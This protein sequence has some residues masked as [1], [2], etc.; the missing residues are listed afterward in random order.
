VDPWIYVQGHGNPHDDT[1]ATSCPHRQEITREGLIEQFE[2]VAGKP[3]EGLFKENIDEMV[4]K[5][6]TFRM[7]T[8]RCCTTCVDVPDVCKQLPT[9]DKLDGW[10]SCWLTHYPEKWW[11]PPKEEKEKEE[12]EEEAPCKNCKHY[13]PDTRYCSK[14][15]GHNHGCRWYHVGTVDGP[16]SGDHEHVNDLFESKEEKEVK[17]VPPQHYDDEGW[18]IKAP[19]CKDC[20]HRHD[21]TVHESIFSPGEHELSRCGADAGYW[22]ARTKANSGPGVQTGECR[23]HEGEKEE[24]E[25]EVKEEEEKE[26][27]CELC[28]HYEVDQHPRCGVGGGVR[29]LNPRDGCKWFHPTIMEWCT[30]NHIHDED[31]FEPK[32]IEER[33][34]EEEKKC[35]SCGTCGNGIYKH[36]DKP[37]C[38]TSKLT[39]CIYFHD[40]RTGPCQSPSIPH[41]ED[42]W[43]PKKIEVLEV[44]DDDTVTVELNSDE[45]EYIGKKKV[46]V[47]C[48][49]CEHAFDVFKRGKAWWCSCRVATPTMSNEQFYTNNKQC[50]RFS[51]YD[52]TADRP[53]DYACKECA[54]NNLKKPFDTAP[55]NGPPFCMKYF[56]FDDKRGCGGRNFRPRSILKDP[57]PLVA[58]RDCECASGVYKDDDGWK[59]RCKHVPTGIF[60]YTDTKICERFSRYEPPTHH[61]VC[62]DGCAWRVTDHRECDYHDIFNEY[63]L[64]GVE[65]ISHKYRPAS[66]LK[67]NEDVSNVIKHRGLGTLDID[68]DDKTPVY[69][70]A[71]TKSPGGRVDVDHVSVTGID[72]DDEDL[73]DTDE[74]DWQYVAD[75]GD[76]VHQH[77]TEIVDATPGVYVHCHEGN[78]IKTTYGDTCARASTRGQE[79]VSYKAPEREEEPEKI[80]EKEN[81][82]VL[83]DGERVGEATINWAGNTITAR[84]DSGSVTFQSPTPLYKMTVPPGT[85]EKEAK[86]F[87]K[88]LGHVAKHTVFIPGDEFDFTEVGPPVMD[89][90]G[91]DDKLDEILDVL[92]AGVNVMNTIGEI[93]DLPRIP[94]FERGRLHEILKIHDEKDKESD[95]KES[96]NEMVTEKKEYKKYCR[97]CDKWIKCAS[98]AEKKSMEYC[99]ECGTAFTRWYQKVRWVLGSG[100]GRVR[101]WHRNWRASRRDAEIDRLKRH[102]KA[103]QAREGELIEENTETRKKMRLDKLATNDLIMKA[104]EERDAVIQK[105]HEKMD[106][107]IKDRERNWVPLANALP[108]KIVTV[109]MGTVG[110]KSIPSMQARLFYDDKH[111]MIDIVAPSNWVVF[112]RRTLPK[113]ALPKQEENDDT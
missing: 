59:C 110:Y 86:R 34:G 61:L 25:K 96:E 94:A 52:P 31:M 105:H 33:E 57:A 15:N 19:A 111:G 48:R 99:P 37:V 69:G 20:K 80:V 13:N 83:K 29:G 7:I 5:G 55:H 112:D 95:E 79:C 74:P 41:D 36:C 54:F 9:S 97:G 42:L 100:T 93:F 104:R 90:A 44:N 35:C 107:I 98:K 85:T 56:K 39:K 22:M 63:P 6:I 40:D 101:A 8:K 89:T 76:C 109:D 21:A 67:K 53:D 2:E 27:P 17:K 65:G 91:I 106:E 82:P 4:E 113:N 32:E 45:L 26:A 77:D 62:D 84:I 43:V 66:I 60:S 92:N 24:E 11:C 68:L 72:L 51:R 87:A 18:A 10:T 14:G 88:R 50:S 23:H 78:V 1:P 102:V 28:K 103:L 73:E 38:E 71:Y 30:A 58:C 64:C 16:C 46:L 70:I 108:I 81:I 75:C 3:I 47:R 12:D 49:D